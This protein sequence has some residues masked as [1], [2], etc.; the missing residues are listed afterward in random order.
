MIARRVML[1]T[2]S[3]IVFWALTGVPARYM[4][5]NELTLIH[6]GTAMLLCLVP[7][8]ITLAWAG[9]AFQHDPEQQLFMILGGTGLRLFGVLAVAMLLYF[10]VPPFQAAFGF[11]VWLVVYYL[12]T[13]TMEMLLL[14]QARSGSAGRPV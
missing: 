11:L 2:I 7:G 14:L 9:W 3:C 8:I 13:L 6:S 10:N 12:G 1:F 5:D 4:L